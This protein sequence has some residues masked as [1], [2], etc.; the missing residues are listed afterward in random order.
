MYPE[1]PR[2]K[3]PHQ[4]L[5]YWKHIF[6]L[7]LAYNASGEGD[8]GVEGRRVGGGERG[9]IGT[10]WMSVCGFC[11]IV[12][13][14]PM[15]PRWMKENFFLSHTIIFKFIIPLWVIASDNIETYCKK[16]YSNLVSLA[17]ILNERKMGET[18]FSV[19]NTYRNGKSFVGLTSMLRNN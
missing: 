11:I 15:S 10:A 6:Q 12:S 8:E 18:F 4:K 2:M 9:G 1:L 14:L 17:V 5:L 19:K 3:T 16:Y 7:N 13:P